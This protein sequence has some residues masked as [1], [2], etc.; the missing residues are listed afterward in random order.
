MVGPWDGSSAQ[1][2]SRSSLAP[3]LPPFVSVFSR[4]ARVL[5]LA[6]SSLPRPTLLSGDRMIL[7]IS[8][9]VAEQ[10][11]PLIPI[12]P[13]SPPVAVSDSFTQDP[14]KGNVCPTLSACCNRWAKNGLW[15]IRGEAGQEACLPLIC[16]LFQLRSSFRSAAPFMSEHMIL[17]ANSEKVTHLRKNV[18]V[19][20]LLRGA[21]EGMLHMHA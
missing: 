16:L 15:G 8:A 6:L 10:G 4:V 1:E 7:I 19:M 20:Q 3:H 9:P 2:F 21:R 18:P 11:S 12:H 13:N 5:P 14:L 17:A